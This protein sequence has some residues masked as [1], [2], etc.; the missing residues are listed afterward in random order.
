METD[1]SYHAAIDGKQDGPFD[2]DALE[3]F[4]KKGKFNKETLVWKPGMAYWMS[5]GEVA[6]LSPVFAPPP[7]PAT[8]TAKT[9]PNLQQASSV[10]ATKEEQKLKKSITSSVIN[11]ILGI[12]ICLDFLFDANIIDDLL[13]SF[14]GSSEITYIIHIIGLLALISGTFTLLRAKHKLKELK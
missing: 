1:L 8:A 7:L 12:L 13:F 10:D 4:I 2:F 11:I 3:V 5:A 9:E 14:L 6:E